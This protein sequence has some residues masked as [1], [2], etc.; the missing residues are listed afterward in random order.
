MRWLGMQSGVWCV[1]TTMGRTLL[2]SLSFAFPPL[3]HLHPPMTQNN[4]L[5]LHRDRPQGLSELR[6][7]CAWAWMHECILP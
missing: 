2:S 7:I 5:I 3:C 4:T 6:A 1:E